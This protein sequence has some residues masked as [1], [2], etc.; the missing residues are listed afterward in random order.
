ML[1]G[2]QDV[3][4]AQG[5]LERGIAGVAGGLFE[6]GTGGDLDVDDPEFNAEIVADGLA[7][8]RPGV[9]GGLQTVMDMN[10]PQRGDAWWRT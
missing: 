7:V 2:E 4:G 5:L 10:R 3:A 9:G 1:A 6:A 8:S